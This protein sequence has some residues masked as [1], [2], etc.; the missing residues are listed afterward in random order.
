MATTPKKKNL[1]VFESKKKIKR[2]KKIALGGKKK[3]ILKRVQLYKNNFLDNG[4]I[5]LP[6]KERVVKVFGLLVGVPAE[7]L[8]TLGE[9][10]VLIL[11]VLAFINLLSTFLLFIIFF[12]LFKFTD[13]FWP[14]SIILSKLKKLNFLNKLRVFFFTLFFS[15]P[16]KL[17]VNH[18]VNSSFEF[19]LLFLI[20][21]YVSIIP[22]YIFFVFY[23]FFLI[24][25]SYLFAT[26]YK[27]NEFFRSLVVYFLFNNDKLLADIYFS[28]FWGNMNFGSIKRG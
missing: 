9:P 10:T 25:E 18:S 13:Y 11:S 26:A 1:N 20:F 5:L 2:S 22:M 28:F 19:V 23:Y 21:L 27:T 15:I 17:L 4:R 12:L 3:L 8:V 6:L 16:N 7:E 14:F 24:V